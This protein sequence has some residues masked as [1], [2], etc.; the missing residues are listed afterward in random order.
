MHGKKDKSVPYALAEEMHAG[1]KGSKI[2]T[3]AGGHLFFFMKE[4]QQFLACAHLSGAQLD[5]TTKGTF[6]SMRE[7]L[8]HLFAAEEGLSFQHLH[9][10]KQVFL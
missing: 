4:R 7:T 6:G 10:G 9:L 5:A 3:F 1:I 8:L 2:L